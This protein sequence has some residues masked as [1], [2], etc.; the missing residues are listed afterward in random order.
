MIPLVRPAPCSRQ[1]WL[2]NWRCYSFHRSAWACRGP[3]VAR[4]RLPPSCPLPSTT[5]AR[6]WQKIRG[7]V[8][9]IRAHMTRSH[10]WYECDRWSFAKL[11]QP[12]RDSVSATWRH[13]VSRRCN[14]SGATDT[15][16]AARLPKTAK[17]NLR[18]YGHA[19][20]GIALYVNLC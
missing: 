15:M 19:A 7:C 11:G 20:G 6:R 9:I 18:D 12:R 8:Q 1:R 13:M 17:L 3:A 16:N 4:W 14:A 5:T 2:Q 10:K